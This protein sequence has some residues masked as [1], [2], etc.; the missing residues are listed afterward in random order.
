[1]TVGN[2][3]TELRK[4][5]GMTQEQLAD[6]IG[7]TRQAVSKWESAKSSPNVE[8]VIQMGKLFDVSMDY[9]LLGEDNTA[10][11]KA[12]MSTTGA[13]PHTGKNHRGTIFLILLV[14][15]IALVCLLPLFA[16][17]YQSQIMSIGAPYHTDANLYLSEWPLL[18]V[19]LLSCIPLIMGLLGLLWPSLT[20]LSASII[21][22]WKAA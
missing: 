22:H 4:K 14:V 6:A 17:L 8:F 13:Q 18:G 2:R 21:E 1:M 5:R 10:T 15:G 11:T 19:V 3:I 7:A 9:L 12:E 16:S 20:R